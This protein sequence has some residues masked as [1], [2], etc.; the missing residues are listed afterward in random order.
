ML[1]VLLTA[2][3]GSARADYAQEVRLDKPLAWWR[4]DDQASASGA[5]A[6]DQM[7]VHPGTYHGGAALEAEGPPTGGK[8]ANFDG[9]SYVEIPHH[10]D[11]ALST[12]SVEFWFKSKQAWDQPYWPGSAAL[13]S[14]ATAGVGSGDWTIIAGSTTAGRNQGRIIAAS[15]PRDANR[16]QLLA[17]RGR[18]NDG[19]W[20]Q[21]VWTRS[22]NGACALYLDGRFAGEANDGGL[23][24]TNSRPIQLGGEAALEGGKYLKGSL[25]E[26]AIYSTA[27]DVKRVRA[28]YAAAFPNSTLPT[29]EVAGGASEN[30]AE[31]I[32]L[33]NS[34]GLRWELE[35][36]TAGWS[37]GRLLLHGK[38]VDQ[39]LSQ[40]VLCLHQTDLDEDL[41]LPASEA[42][43]V[44]GR[45]ARLSGQKPVDGALFRFEVEVSVGEDAPHAAL[46][47]RW[48]V[49]RDLEGWEVALAYHGVGES[50]WRCTVYPFAGNAPELGLERVV[51][52]GV[53]SVVVFRPDLSLV[54]L[55]GIDP[56]FDYLNPTTWTGATGFQF[57]NRLT[58][59][60]F[61]VGGGKLKAGVPYSMP[62]QVFLN[63]SG[64]SPQ[65]ISQLVRDW[66]KVNRYEVQPMFIRTA[67]EALALYLKG[68]RSTKMWKPGKGYQLQDV[69]AAIYIPVSPQSAFFEYL[70]YSQTGDPLWRQRCLEQMDFTLKAQL[71]DPS[72]PLFGYMHTCYMIADNSFNSDDRGSN[73]GYKVDMNVHTARYMLQTWEL[74]KQKEGIDRQDWYQAAVRAVDWALQQQNPDGGLPQKLDYKTLK[75]SVSVCSG[76]TMAALPIIA[77][78]TGDAK[79]LK[80][81]EQLDP[82]LR[83]KVEDRYWFTGQHPDLYPED[84]ESDSIWSVCEY[85]LDKYDR[86]GDPECLRRAEANGWFGFL[87]LCPKQLSWIKNPTQTCHT[88]QLHYQQY[89]NYAYHNKKLACLR[90]LGQLTKESVFTQLY[91]RIVQC[92]FWAQQTGGEYAGAQYERMAD[93]WKGVSQEVDSK[94]TLYMNELSLD[95]NLQ[96]LEMGV[97]KAKPAELK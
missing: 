25:A 40:G 96:L 93:P 18:L 19:Q 13:V 23:A 73:P 57:R 1:L 81:L 6:R 62:L 63:D 52:V 22:A 86:T 47:P 76:R 7:G 14:K 72:S 8:A 68:R 34:A 89:S 85:W 2:C 27:L 39:P 12:L 45:T 74:L 3:A 53:P 66:V 90:R 37:L 5:V 10:A 84:F 28:H 42:R 43:Q 83:Q 67:D 30:P 9:K 91:E 46:T 65:A 71:T 50:D 24:I 26:V 51:S 4:F 64:N 56:S 11:F 87:M 38:P 29:E 36:R 33:T 17:S 70:V 49:D 55:F 59:P 94:G 60:Q 79:Y 20:H 61:R 32:V 92:G 69:W 58:A 44:N 78:I 97:S 48:S 15:G 95:A 80:T 35:R 31:L 75:K 77:R 21:V 82:F 54:T 88:E 41:W 16:D